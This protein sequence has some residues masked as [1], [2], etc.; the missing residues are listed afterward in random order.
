[1][2]E[3]TQNPATTKRTNQSTPSPRSTKKDENQDDT[4]LIVIVVF[5]LCIAGGFCST[6][7]VLLWYVR[8][9]N[10]SNVEGGDDAKEQKFQEIPLNEGTS[11][12]LKDCGA[13]EY[14]F[15]G[16]IYRYTSV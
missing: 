16:Q 3:F 4:E 6:F 12:A 1:M 14:Q 13:A 8:H 2:T 7:V 10:D 15:L 9:R 5:V 11:N